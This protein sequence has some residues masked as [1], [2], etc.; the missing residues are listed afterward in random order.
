MD[1]GYTEKVPAS[2][3]DSASP[4]S[5]CK[6]KTYYPSM[7]VRSK[8]KLDFPDGEFKFTGVGKVVSRTERKESRGEED[9][10]EESCS[11]EIEVTS[12]EPIGGSKSAPK[13]EGL[14]SFK[15]AFGKAARKKMADYEEE[16]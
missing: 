7:Y 6:E 13:A 12:M 16:D 8:E 11:Y 4:S 5:D 1:L 9:D 3:C 14:V 2:P 15:E 10:G